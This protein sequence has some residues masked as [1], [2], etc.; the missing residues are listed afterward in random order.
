MRPKERSESEKNLDGPE[1]FHE[2]AG[3]GL[4]LLVRVVVKVVA[5]VAV[6]APERAREDVHAEGVL[7]GE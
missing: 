7:G 3:F 6:E 4:L 2:R 5:L 1:R